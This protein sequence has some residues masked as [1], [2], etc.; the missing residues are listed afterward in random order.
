MLFA[1]DE[2]TL[3]RLVNGIV[4]FGVVFGKGHGAAKGLRLPF[5]DNESER[6]RKLLA[7]REGLVD[8][9]KEGVRLP[10]RM[11]RNVSLIVTLSPAV[12]VEAV[13]IVNVPAELTD[14]GN[15]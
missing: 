13:P 14:C 2:L 4:S 15:D 7:D 10:S 1:G 5:E 8:R 6:W 11:H 9:E 12:V 3:S